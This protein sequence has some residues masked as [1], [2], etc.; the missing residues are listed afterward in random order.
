M[1]VSSDGEDRLRR[2][3]TSRVTGS[4]S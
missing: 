1:T 4:R 2:Q 3:V